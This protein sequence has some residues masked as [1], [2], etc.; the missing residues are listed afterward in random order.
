MSAE[1]EEKTAIEATEEIW[2]LALEWLESK[3]AREEMKTRMDDIEMQIRDFAD[4]ATLVTHKG[5][6]L[7]EFKPKKDTFIV[8]SK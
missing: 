4:G 6:K 8:R 7:V 5:E 1:Y 2:G 3:L